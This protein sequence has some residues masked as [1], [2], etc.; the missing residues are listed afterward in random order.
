MLVREVLK[1]IVV[2]VRLFCARRQR[3]VQAT[4]GPLNKI[5]ALGSRGLEHAIYQS[6]AF[7]TVPLAS[8]LVGLVN[9]DFRASNV[10]RDSAA[11]V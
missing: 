3:M 5:P 11:K 8:R 4:V 7:T 10:A 2:L 1:V 9:R 6:M